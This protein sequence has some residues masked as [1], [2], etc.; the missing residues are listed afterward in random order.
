[1]TSRSCIFLIFMPSRVQSR[2]AFRRVT[3]IWS[4][5]PYVNPQILI[6][7]FP[8]IN[9]PALALIS[10]RFPSPP[11]TWEDHVLCGEG[12]GPDSA[13]PLIFDSGVQIFLFLKFDCWVKS[14]SFT[15]EDLGAL[16]NLTIPLGQDQRATTKGSGPKGQEQLGK[17][18]RAMT[19]GPEPK[20][21]DQRASSET[22]F[23]FC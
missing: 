2:R 1:M 21:Q 3:Y 13:M 8:S 5:V 12:G 6:S 9:S 11:I 22:E 14:K 15:I 19:K 17:D 16:R 18:Q 10:S 4:A 20:S 7:R 23:C